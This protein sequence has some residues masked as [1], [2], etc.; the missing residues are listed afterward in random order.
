MLQ[1]KLESLFIYPVKSLGGVEVSELEFDRWGPKFDRR[2]MLTD[3]TGKFMTQ[4]K[5]PALA[6]I[7][8][9][10]TNNNLAFEH[11]KHRFIL[12]LDG[13]D[14]KTCQATIWSFSGPM[15]DYGDKIADFLSTILKQSCRLVGI[16]SEHQRLSNGAQQYP[17]GLCD[18]RQ[19]LITSLESLNWLNQQLVF[20]NEN[21][22]TMDRFRPN[23]VVSGG[24][25]TFYENSWQQLTIGDLTFVREKS[26]ERCI[27]ITIDQ[28]DGVRK[29]IAPL[30]ILA[31]HNRGDQGKAPAFGTYFSVLNTGSLSKSS[32]ITF[33]RQ[34]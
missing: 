6:S 12:N 29:S 21:A 15:Q 2:F 17:I 4:K 30:N 13:D 14:Y 11:N 5:C 25:N 3:T 1:L 16:T 19:V 32:P 22:V 28:R 7:K 10:L 9:K 24:N 33:S 31:K 26:C 27:M 18:S 20:H 8:V 23:I 34:K